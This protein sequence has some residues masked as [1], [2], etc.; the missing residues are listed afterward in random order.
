[1]LLKI[2]VIHTYYKNMSLRDTLSPSAWES[3]LWV[4]AGISGLGV[5]WKVWSL[6]A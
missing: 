4:P 6:E 2:K 1:M 3:L 5:W